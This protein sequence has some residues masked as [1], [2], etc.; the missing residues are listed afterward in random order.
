MRAAR[1]DAHARDAQAAAGKPAYRDG[2]GP[3]AATRHPPNA[4]DPDQ[5]H[6]A[7]G[8]ACATNGA[9]VLCRGVCANHRGGFSGRPATR[10]RLSRLSG[11]RSRR[12]FGLGRTASRCTD[13][14]HA[15]APPLIHSSAANPRRTALRRTPAADGPPTSVLHWLD[16]T[17][18]AEPFF[19]WVQLLLDAHA[20]YEP[21]PRVRRERGLRV[22]RGAKSRSWDS[23]DRPAH[24][25]VS[26]AT[27]GMG[28]TL[29]LVHRRSWREHW[30]ST[31]GHPRH[32]S[33][34]DATRA[35]AEFIPAGP[36]VPAGLRGHDRG[37]AASTVAPTLLDI[38]P[39]SSRRAH[40]RPL[41][42]GPGP[43][44]V[45]ASRMPTTLFG[46]RCTSQ[47]QLRLGASLLRLRTARHK[48]DRGSR[49][50]SS[51]TSEGPTPRRRWTARPPG[52]V[53]ASKI[54]G[55]RSQKMMTIRD[56]PSRPAPWT[57]RPRRAPM[58]A[59]IS[60]VEAA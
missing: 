39:A 2:R 12:R 29:V 21:P 34:Y 32:P 27:R 22:T 58:R 14:H 40:G 10:P 44:R 51:T 28:G 53:L 26:R 57:Q 19:M 15:A 33:L 54:C 1:T 24:H 50:R 43:V 56:G 17:S 7:S 55:A 13:D 9:Y 59:A 41:C 3:S 8:T 4:S 25:G 30:A 35:G 49:A 38:T 23:P 16:T 20:P 42:C 60:A 11:S 31:G 37:G 45:S 47:L 48:L 52:S 18:S 46:S 5:P 6:P 36:N